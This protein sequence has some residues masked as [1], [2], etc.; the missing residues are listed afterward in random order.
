MDDTAIKWSHVGA[1]N[2]ALD[3]IL[4][5]KKRTIEEALEIQD[6][7]E[8]RSELMGLLPGIRLVKG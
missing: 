3:R 1:L 7:R 4:A 5:K 8:R 6:L 2:T